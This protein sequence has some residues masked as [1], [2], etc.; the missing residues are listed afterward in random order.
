MTNRVRVGTVDDAG[1]ARVVLV[2]DDGAQFADDVL[3]AAP[4]DVRTLIAEWPQHREAVLTAAE[5]AD[6]SALISTAELTWLAP[7]VPHKIICVGS[8]YHDHVAEMEGPAG[9]VSRPAPFAYSF[10]KPATTLVGSGSG[11]AHPSYGSKLDWEVEL[12]VVIGD[13]TA[14]AGPEPLD[15]VFGYTIL[16]DLSLRDFIPFPHALG[17]DALVSKGFDGAAPTGPWITLAGDIPDPQALPLQLSIDGEVMQDSSTSNMIFGVRD[18]VAHYGRV[19]TLEPGDIIATGTPAGVGAA[20][21][22]P[23]YLK[24]G[25]LVEARIGELGTLRTTITEPGADRPLLATTTEIS[26]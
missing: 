8:N 9:V 13:G 16:N 23:R 21:R 22:P 1:R 26:A 20:R 17:L 7:V 2:F 19:L 10:L 3:P 4:A 18:L 15:A 6:A 24:P 5:R 25:E 14:A 12:A 11:V